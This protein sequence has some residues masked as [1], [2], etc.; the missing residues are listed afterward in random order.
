MAYDIESYNSLGL[1]SDILEVS[2]ADQPSV[3][4]IQHIQQALT[5]AFAD[6]KQQGTHDLKHRLN[7]ENRSASKRVREL[8]REQWS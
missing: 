3:L 2:N 1:L 8:L 6:I 7:A 4:D 5:A